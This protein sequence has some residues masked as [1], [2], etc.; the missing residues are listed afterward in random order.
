M[1]ARWTLSLPQTSRANPV[2]CC[3]THQKKKKRGRKRARYAVMKYTD[4]S[5]VN[6]R[7]QT[8]VAPGNKQIYSVIISYHS[9]PPPPSPPTLIRK[10]SHTH[11]HVRWFLRCRKIINYR[12]E[13]LW[14]K[15]FWNADFLST[16]TTH[17]TAS[18][19]LKRE[20]GRMGRDTQRWG[21]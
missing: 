20:R 13:C 7:F 5:N 9:N 14:R 4:L 17:S 2:Q 8:L 1:K 11:T 6:S 18:P 21:G 15:Y 19:S 16:L 3:S 10:L 12:I